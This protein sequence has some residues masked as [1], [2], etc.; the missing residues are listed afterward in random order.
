MNNP[1]LI[2]TGCLRQKAINP[3]GNCSIA[4]DTAKISNDAIPLNNF[5]S[6]GTV[7]ETLCIYFLLE[8]SSLL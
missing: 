6:K 7:L 1:T 5:L 3:T 8:K 4:I 2:Y